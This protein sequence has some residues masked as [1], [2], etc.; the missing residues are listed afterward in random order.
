MLTAKACQA[1]KTRRYNTLMKH[2]S[3]ADRKKTGLQRVLLRWFRSNA[4]DVP[5][6]R[7]RDPYRIWVSEILLQQTR[8]ETAR[9][10]Y[11]RFVK[12]LPRLPALAA[13]SEDAVLKLWEGL[14]YYGRARNLLNAA[15]IIQDERGGRFPE[16]AKEWGELPGI[17]RYTAGAIASIALGEPVPVLDGNVKRVLARIFRVRRVIDTTATV[18]MLWGLAEALIP[19]ESPGDF[20]Q[21]LMELGAR[22]CLPGRPRCSVCP[23]AGLCE[24]RARGEEGRLPIHRRKKP[25]PHREVVAAFIQSGGRYLLARRPA[26]GMLGGLWE[27]PGGAV[28]PGESPAA[29]LRRKL[30][31]DLGI[32]VQVGR[33]VGSVNHAFT[34]FS[35]TLHLHVCKISG[36]RPVARRYTD[37]KWVYR[38][39]FDRYALPA[40]DRK[41]F[42]RIDG[43]SE[44]SSL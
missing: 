10:Y 29:A 2:L 13:A 27:F 17:G 34:H 9:D 39:D 44:G 26:A 42:S 20:N 38:S 5:W 23:A 22:V 37:V 4:R 28:K 16:S 8:F 30:R 15:R 41:L 24:A 33:E 3:D 32:R 1:M 43:S 7:T 25:I 18:K 12:A 35:M 40:A 11:V 36:G 6:R 31:A 14:G 19:R 21:A